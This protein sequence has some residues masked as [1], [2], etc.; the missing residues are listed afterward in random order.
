MGTGGGRFCGETAPKGTT[1]QV[2]GRTAR[3]PSAARLDVGGGCPKSVSGWPRVPRG[4]V[5][6]PGARR[7]SRGGAA[8]AVSF[9]QIFVSFVQILGRGEALLGH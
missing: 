3:V 8:A 7:Q 9:V 4:C 2:A 1:P 6:R 5:S